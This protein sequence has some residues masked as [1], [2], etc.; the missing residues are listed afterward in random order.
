MVMPAAREPA[1][2][3][4]IAYAAR[5][6]VGIPVGISQMR[7]R[8]LFYFQPVMVLGD[9][10]PGADRGNESAWELQQLVRDKC[11]RNRTADVRRN[12]IACKRPTPLLRISLLRRLNRSDE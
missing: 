10:R 3:F 8:K 12:R 11:D 7:R 1:I 6:F 2:I 9:Y 4:A 5:K